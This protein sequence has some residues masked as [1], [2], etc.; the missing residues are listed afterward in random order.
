MFLVYHLFR[1][2]DLN[3]EQMWH[4]SSLSSFNSNVMFD[5]VDVVSPT[6]RCPPLPRPLP[7]PP[8][9]LPLPLSVTGGWLFEGFDSSVLNYR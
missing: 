9:P 7:L 8:R 3:L 6:L 1:F 2:I 5:F 4:L